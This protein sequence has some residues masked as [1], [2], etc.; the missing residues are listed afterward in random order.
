MQQYV[1]ICI[2][3]INHNL[4]LSRW[5]Y[6]VYQEKGLRDKERYKAEMLEYKSSQHVQ[7]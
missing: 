5:W 6:Q 1:E 2:P 7:G 4:I 3:E